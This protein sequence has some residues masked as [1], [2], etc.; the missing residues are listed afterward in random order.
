MKMS[1]YSVF[2]KEYINTKNGSVAC[3][4]GVSPGSVQRAV[5]PACNVLV[6]DV[7]IVKHHPE[8]YFIT[9]IHQHHFAIA[10]GRGPIPV[11]QVRQ[12][13]LEAHADNVFMDYHVRVELEK[14]AIVG[15]EP[16]YEQEQ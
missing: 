11:E 15:M 3:I 13:R 4:D 9:F 12:W 6:N 7:C 14:Y 1:A 16:A 10:V 8:Q 5:A 2:K